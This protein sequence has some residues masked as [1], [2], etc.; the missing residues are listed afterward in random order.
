MVIVLEVDLGVTEVLVFD[1]CTYE[2]SAKL[3]FVRCYVYLVTDV[4]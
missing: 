4:S 3:R 1:R 2:I